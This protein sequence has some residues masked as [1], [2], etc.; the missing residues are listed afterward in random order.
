MITSAVRLFTPWI[1]SSCGSGLLGGQ[2]P[3]L[4][5]YVTVIEAGQRPSLADY[6][7]VIEASDRATAAR[8]P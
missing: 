4:A 6:V 5:D 2:R 7:T 8:R 3:S 1:V